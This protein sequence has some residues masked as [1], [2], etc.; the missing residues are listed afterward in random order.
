MHDYKATIRWTRRDAN[1]TNLRYSRGHEWMFDGGAK[2]KA[3]SSPRVVPLPYSIPEAVD[4]EEALVASASS[5]HMLSFLY[6]AARGGFVVDNYQDE[7]V[8]VMDKNEAGKQAITLITLH[9]RI[10]FSGDKKPTAK[11]LEDLHHQAHSE[12]YIANS[13]K[14][15]VVVAKP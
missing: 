13:I 6:F 2:V 9:P 15:D 10:D 12:C 7:P 14:C 3:S 1:F 4:P 11:E 8:G 5:C